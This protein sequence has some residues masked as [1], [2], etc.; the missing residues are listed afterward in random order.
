MIQSPFR[1]VMGIDE[2]LFK[3]ALEKEFFDFKNL[4][5]PEETNEDGC[6]E[7]IVLINISKNFVTVLGNEPIKP[8][9]KSVKKAS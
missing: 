2:F 4:A 6:T 5:I 7:K 3:Y 9:S 1:F 8:K